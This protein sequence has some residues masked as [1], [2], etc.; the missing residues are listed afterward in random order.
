MSP[1]WLA[2]LSLLLVSACRIGRLEP[3]ESSIEALAEL[4]GQ[5]E[6]GM[7][8]P[9][10]RAHVELSEFAITHFQELEL[11]VDLVSGQG[12]ERQG[13]VAR[14]LDDI[15][16]ESVRAPFGGPLS[17]TLELS[18]VLRAVPCDAVPCR[19]TLELLPDGEWSSD[20]SFPIRYEVSAELALER[21]DRLAFDGDLE[22]VLELIP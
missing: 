7:S 5:R 18:S 3:E 4:D 16:D 19:V 15:A 14:W 11:Q 17:N 8:P 1:R 20:V 9:L 22:L 2:C 12:L 13:L 10:I 6:L 21:R